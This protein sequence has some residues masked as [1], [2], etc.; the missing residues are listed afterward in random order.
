MKVLTNHYEIWYVICALNVTVNIGASTLF[1][2]FS[3]KYLK[4]YLHELFLFNRSKSIIASTVKV[5]SK[6]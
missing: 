1:P 6:Q 2:S 4:I 5:D 3:K